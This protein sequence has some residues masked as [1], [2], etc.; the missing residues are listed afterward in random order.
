MSTILRAEQA[1]SVHGVDA[2]AYNVVLWPNDPKV[3]ER[4]L[5]AFVIL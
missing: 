2:R 1:L 3:P 4:A 5:A